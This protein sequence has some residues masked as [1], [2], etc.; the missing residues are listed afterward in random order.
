MDGPIFVVN[1][2]SSSIKF[3]AYRAADGSAAA[4]QFKGQVEGIGSA[5]HMAA[6]RTD[7]TK[8]AE[9]RWPSGSGLDH[10]AVFEVL[11]GWVNEHL[12]QAPV[13][14]GHRIV[15]GGSRFAGPVR[16]DQGVV[17]ALDALC[18]L[19]PL[20]QPHNLAAVRAIRPR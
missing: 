18:P 5:P 10:E 11:T 1:A 14:V 17:D 13:G 6:Y 12:N 8:I 2:G 19:A 20:H 4:L 16:I 7:G 9:R 3:S 15:H